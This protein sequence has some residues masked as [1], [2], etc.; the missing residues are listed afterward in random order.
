MQIKN[1]EAHSLKMKVKWGIMITTFVV[2]AAF[3]HNTDQLV[4][5]DIKPCREIAINTDLPTNVSAAVRHWSQVLLL[6]LLLFIILCSCARARN[7]YRAFRGK[8]V[9]QAEN[10]RQMVTGDSDRIPFLLQVCRAAERI[11]L[12][13]ADISLRQTV[14]RFNGENRSESVANLACLPE[15]CIFWFDRGL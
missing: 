1:S 6:P 3:P 2:Q 4:Q 11:H 10:I 7:N 14:W 8:G 9:C 13:G 12:A 15:R 5:T